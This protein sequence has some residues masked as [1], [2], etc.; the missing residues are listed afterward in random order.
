MKHLAIIVVLVVVLVALGVSAAIAHDM[1]RSRS[2]TSR[3]QSVQIGDS[4]EQVLAKVGRATE[5]FTAPQEIPGI[6]YLGVRV[7]T[8]AYGERFNWQHCFYPRFPYFWPLKVRLFRPDADD[9]TV[10]FDS[11][12]RVSHVSTPQT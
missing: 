11:T 7:E 10:E 1:S 9:V 3:V 6:F 5:V 4:K 12:G 8:W 2:F